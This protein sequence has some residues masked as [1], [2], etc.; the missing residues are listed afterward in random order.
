[1]D[2]GD[3]QAVVEDLD[4]AKHNVVSIRPSCLLQCVQKVVCCE[5]LVRPHVDLGVHDDRSVPAAA[6]RKGGYTA[7]KYFPQLL[8]LLLL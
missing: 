5:V 4:E 8:L 1:M 7:Q 6:K 3:I 2:R